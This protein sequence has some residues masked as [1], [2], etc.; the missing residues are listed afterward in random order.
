MSKKDKM[1]KMFK[2]LDPDIGDIKSIN[3]VNKLPIS[4]F[5]FLSLQDEAFVEQLFGI[6]KISD[7][8]KLDRQNP[9]KKVKRSK[10]KK[11]KF[12]KI[13]KEDPEFE[14]KIKHAI[15]ICSIFQR[16][17]NE[18]VS[19]KRKDQ[20]IIVIGLNNAGKTAI[21]T[22]FDGGLGIKDLALLKPTR[23]VNTQE[24]K[25]RSLNL[26]LWEFGGQV[27]H[28]KEYL[29]EPEKYFFGID[30]VIFVI[31]IQDTERYDESIEYF[32]QIVENIIN[33]EEFPHVLV[34]IHKFDPDIRDNNEVLLNVELIK[35]LIKSIFHEKS[36]NYDIYLTSVYSMISNEPTFSKFLKEIMTNSVNLTDPANLKISE[37]GE[38]VEKALNAVLQ[39]SSIILT[40]ENRIERLE[41]PTRGISTNVA[42]IE[43]LPTPEYSNSA[44]SIPPRS[45]IMSELKDLFVKKRM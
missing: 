15:T 45:A 10:Q 20:K 34:F 22:K 23:G 13:L 31:D 12:S 6:S 36:L 29:N 28:R 8:L 5:K 43:T 14:E 37:L 1:D 40:L 30:L 38:M 3:Q 11:A 19:H 17:I 33:L 18:S 25:I 4:S 26:H 16:L 32:D 39:L 44:I 35:D 42:S 2:F 9:F 7:L 41:S 27:D 21:I 24:I